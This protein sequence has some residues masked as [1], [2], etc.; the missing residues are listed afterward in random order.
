MTI[1]ITAAMSTKIPITLATI[2]V[3]ISTPLCSLGPGSPITLWVVTK[4]KESVVVSAPLVLA[5]ERDGG[6]MWTWL[7]GVHSLY[8]EQ[9]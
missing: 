2:I 4:S 7:W 8:Q 5:V 1:N 9:Q 6:V 3:I